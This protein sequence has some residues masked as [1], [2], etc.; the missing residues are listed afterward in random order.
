[1]SDFEVKKEISL[2]A[3][4]KVAGAI[5]TAL[6]FFFATYSQIETNAENINR[7][8]KETNN[9]RVEQRKFERKVE[10][11]Y[12]RQDVMEQVMKRLERIQS[13]VDQLRLENKKAGQ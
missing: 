12:M 4:L 3:M 1:M 13:S 5:V 9:I 6:I 2:E 11:T 10:S 7:L 8:Q